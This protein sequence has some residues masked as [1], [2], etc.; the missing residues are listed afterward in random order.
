MKVGGE[1][2]SGKLIKKVA[3]IYPTLAVQQKVQGTVRFAAVVSK[4]G[5]IQSLTLMS[6]SPML[7][8]AA[9]DA[10]KQWA[11]QPTLLDGEPVEVATQIEVNFT[12][13]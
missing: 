1:V 5:A 12:L 8:K 2:Q 9:T 6:G 3:P 4:T 13:K 11:Y 10:V 7:V